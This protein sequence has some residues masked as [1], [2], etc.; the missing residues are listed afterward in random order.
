MAYINRTPTLLWINQQIRNFALCSSRSVRCKTHHVIKLIKNTKSTELATK[1]TTCFQRFVTWLM[2]VWI[3]IN[4]TI[5]HNPVIILA[6]PHYLW[7]LIFINNVIYVLLLF[8]LKQLSKVWIILHLTT[9]ISLGRCNKSLVIVMLIKD[10]QQVDSCF[11]D[12]AASIFAIIQT[13]LYNRW[14]N[15]LIKWCQRILFRIGMDWCTF[16]S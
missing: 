9:L 5:I 7:I 4:L 14:K 15:K 16:P 10:Y 1:K 3:K 12:R 13:K 2:L 11:P 8:N 6:L